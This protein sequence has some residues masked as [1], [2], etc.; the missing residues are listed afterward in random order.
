MLFRNNADQT[1][2][3]GPWL[4]YGARLPYEPDLVGFSS[5]RG[6]L[7]WVFATHRYYPGHYKQPNR[8]ERV[9][10]V[11]FR[12]HPT[13][14][15]TC[16][17]DLQ[18]F[19]LHYHESGACLRVRFEVWSLHEDPAANHVHGSGRRDD[20]LVLHPDHCLEFSTEQHPRSLYRDTAG[21]LY[22]S[23]RQ[24]LLLW[25]V[26]KPLIASSSSSNP[27]SCTFCEFEKSNYLFSFVLQPPS[28]GV[29]SAQPACSRRA[30]STRASS[31]SSASAPSSPSSSTMAPGAGPSRP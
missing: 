12:I 15:T 10:G 26:V 25:Y 27:P 4:R 13:W 24:S 18:D 16:A 21:T 31:S 19:W 14:S 7:L 1:S 20:V 6:H 2:D 30:K 9:D 5:G 22:V 28:S 29:F 8:A 3:V 23:W 17:H 11:R